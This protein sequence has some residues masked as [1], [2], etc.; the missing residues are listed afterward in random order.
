M[1]NSI[2]LANLERGPPHFLINFFFKLLVEQQQK[3]VQSILVLFINLN[4]ICQIQ[5][6][7]L[8]K[9]TLNLE[10]FTRVLPWTY[11]WSIYRYT[12]GLA[13]PISTTAWSVTEYCNEQRCIHF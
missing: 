7:K 6:E 8:I 1:L 4:I 5:L 12:P 13:P 11:W 3:H 10:T 9:V 2:A